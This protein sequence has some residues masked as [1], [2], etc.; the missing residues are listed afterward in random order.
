MKIRDRW[1]ASTPENR[2]T[3]VVLMIV[4]VANLANSGSNVI[5]TS[6][7]A[8]TNDDAVVTS[9]RARARQETIDESDRQIRLLMLRT[10]RAG[11]ERD[12]TQLESIAGETRLQEKAQL[13]AVE[14]YAE[15]LQES[16]DDP[17]QFI[18]DCRADR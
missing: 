12:A 18:E 15:V 1:Q 9:C 5:A 16:I 17:E 6:A 13:D 7:S 2:A 3:F 10:I 4:V 14:T 11:V 8:A